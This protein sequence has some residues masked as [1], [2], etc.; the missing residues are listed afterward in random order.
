MLGKIFSKQKKRVFIA[1]LAVAPRNDI[2]QI[3]EE[4]GGSRT[5]K[6]EETLKATLQ[7]IFNMPHVSSI[8]NIEDSDLALDVIIPKYQTGEAGNFGANVIPIPLFWR[9][10]IDVAGRL[11]KI[12]SG[13]THK[14]SHVRVKMP[15]KPYFS[16]LFSFRGIL[17]FQPMFDSKDLYIL[18]VTACSRLINSLKKSV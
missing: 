8:D 5:E 6:V 9:P 1:N 4:I 11:Y 13:K 7:A 17:G 16:R 2:K 18:L 10:K 14:T 3:F 15:W 12:K